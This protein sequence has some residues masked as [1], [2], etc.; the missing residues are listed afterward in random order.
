MRINAA[1]VGVHKMFG[2]FCSDQWLTAQ[3]RHH[4]SPEAD[5]T[6]SAETWIMV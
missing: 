3:G 1:E 6:S 2:N 4:S 5:Q